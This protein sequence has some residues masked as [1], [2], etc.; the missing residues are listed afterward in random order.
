MKVD[1][2]KL[3][4]E[5]EVYGSD[6]TPICDSWSLYL[7]IKITEKDVAMMMAQLKDTRV[8][9]I[10]EKLNNIKDKTGFLKDH[11]LQEDFR[12]QKNLLA[13]NQQKKAHY[14]FIATNFEQYKKL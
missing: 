9:Y 2:Q 14:L 12:L 7:G 6:F 13:E 5:K 10:Q 4:Q 3:K 11:E 1:K 8:R